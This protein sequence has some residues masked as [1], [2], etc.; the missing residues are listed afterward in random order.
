MIESLVILP[1]TPCCLQIRTQL[2]VLIRNLARDEE[3]GIWQ[4][5]VDEDLLQGLAMSLKSDD[6]AEAEL[7]AVCL[8]KMARSSSREALVQDFILDPLVSN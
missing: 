8:T 1:Y 2:L 5:V 6:L 4:R 7:A 3:R